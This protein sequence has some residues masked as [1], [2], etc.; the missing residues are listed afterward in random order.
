M[1]DWLSISSACTQFSLNTAF[2]LLELRLY[3]WNIVF[4]HGTLHPVTSHWTS[5][6]CSPQQQGD[7]MVAL[8]LHCET[9]GVNCSTN[10]WQWNVYHLNLSTVTCNVLNPE[11]LCSSSWNKWW[12][13]VA[14][15]TSH[16]YQLALHKSILCFDASISSHRTC[17][18]VHGKLHTAN[19]VVWPNR[20][21]MAFIIS[22]T[23]NVVEIL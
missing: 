5:K 22:W 3:K 19:T 2:W 20:A 9:R 21:E 18:L 16:S 4:H 7:S 14:E 17:V 1:A 23:K 8:H 15:H 6:P 11:F 13:V 12:A 10:Y